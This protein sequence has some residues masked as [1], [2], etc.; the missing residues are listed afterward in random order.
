METPGMNMENDPQTA[1][2]GRLYLGH[3]PEPPASM[4]TAAPPP[5]PYPIPD[6]MVPRAQELMQATGGED[7]VAALALLSSWNALAQDG[8]S[9]AGRE[10]GLVCPLGLYIVIGE[11]SGSRKSM[12]LKRVFAAHHDADEAASRRWE[13]AKREE[14]NNKRRQPAE[15]GVSLAAG[16]Q[17]QIPR[18]YRPTMVVGNFTVER[19]LERL[20]GGRPSQTALSD[21][22]TA[23][24]GNYS[25][26]DGNRRQ[27]LSVLNG[28]YDGGPISYDRSRMGRGENVYAP[29]GYNFSL[30]WAAQPDPARSLVLSQEA[31]YGF[32][33][34]SLFAV[35]D[36][37]QTGEL[38]DIR[39][40]ALDWMQEIIRHNQQSQDAGVEYESTAPA[41]QVTLYPTP[42]VGELLRAFE[43]DCR[44]RGKRAHSPHARSFWDRAGENASRVGGTIHASRLY[45][46]LIGDHSW[47]QYDLEQATAI[48]VWHGE[49]LDAQSGINEDIEWVKAA[50][51]VAEA[52]PQGVHWRDSNPR[53]P[54]PDGL[55]IPM[56][57]WLQNGGI[58][59]A[60]ILRNNTRAKEWVIEQLE[61]YRYIHKIRHGRYAVSPWVLGY[62]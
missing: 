12:I 57:S 41:A 19:L 54:L 31:T 36:V 61:T 11:E 53:A 44:E 32:A 9:V 42:R 29:R 33:G 22:A 7:R 27:S 49:Q 59:G 58:P 46:G 17:R 4:L 15:S 28:L 23:V 5:P 43:R 20:A 8:Y 26:A 24:M 10:T 50:A 47:D 52:L 56:R 30:C 45:E 1:Q 62:V 3:F 25:F 39:T 37:P 38:E 16:D 6:N 13:D 51:M 40:P 21:E 34:R 35:S 60:G 18:Q 48:I 14:R 55:S 2:N